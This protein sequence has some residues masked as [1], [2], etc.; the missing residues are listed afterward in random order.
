MGGVT[1]RGPSDAQVSK[2]PQWP[3]RESKVWDYGEKRVRSRERESPP[4]TYCRSKCFISMGGELAR[5][6]SLTFVVPRDMA[7]TYGG[8]AAAA[9]WGDDMARH[10]TLMG[11]GLTDWPR[12]A[13]RAKDWRTGQDMRLEQRTDGLAETRDSSKELVDWPRYAT[14]AKDWRTGRDMRLGQRTGR[15]VEICDSSKGLVDWPRYAT[16]ANDWWTDRD[17]RLAEIHRSG[18]GSVEIQE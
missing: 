3:S 10:A 4:F 8:R 5:T 9:S 2:N 15:L 14:R 16:Q 12:Y 18:E 17:T 11:V 13:T 1:Q 6:P 7:E